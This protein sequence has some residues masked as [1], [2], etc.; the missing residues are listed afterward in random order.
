MYRRAAFRFWISRQHDACFPRDGELVT[1]KD[2]DQFYD[3]LMFHR[4][5]Q[6]I[7]SS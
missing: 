3:I 6:G 7:E 5:E 1:I 4:R 2:P